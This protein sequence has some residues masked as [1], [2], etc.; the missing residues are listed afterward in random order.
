[1]TLTE[2]RKILEKFQGGYDTDPDAVHEAIA[3]VITV[4][5][6]SKGRPTARERLDHIRGVI[7]DAKDGFD[8]FA[9]RTRERECVTWRNCVYL[10]LRKE[11][12]SFSEIGKAAGYDHSTV[13]AGCAALRGFLDT[14]DTLTADVW[15]EF[16]RLAL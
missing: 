9:K 10:L 1:M 6:K 13:L 5:P 15:N 8:P 2:A 16:I 4:L 3:L 11:G 12:Y 14:K 7:T